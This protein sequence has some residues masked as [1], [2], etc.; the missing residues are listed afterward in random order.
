MDEEED[1]KR[2]Q[3]VQIKKTEFM[4]D[5]QKRTMLQIIDISANILYDKVKAMNQ[6]QALI[7]ACVS[8][9]LRN[10]LNSIIAQNIEKKFLFEQMKELLLRK[11]LSQRVLRT[12][13][14]QLNKIIM[15][16]LKI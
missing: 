16:G 1:I 6:F 13:L 15:E 8:H 10:P 12:R 2:S 5:G 4:I 9:E 14:L 3:Y 7:N 11:D